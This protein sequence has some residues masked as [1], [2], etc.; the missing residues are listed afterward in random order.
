MNGPP[1]GRIPRFHDP[2]GPGSGAA[3]PVGAGGFS[4]LEHTDQQPVRHIERQHREPD[5]EGPLR[6]RVGNQHPDQDTDRGQQADDR[7]VFPANV[8]IPCWRQAP[9]IETSAII[10]SE[11]EMALIWPMPS[12]MVIVGTKTTPPPTPISPPMMPPIT[13]RIGPP[14]CP[15][16]EHHF[17]RDT[18]QQDGEDEGHGFLRD[19]LLDRGADDDSDDRR[20][21]QDQGGFDVDVAVD[22]ALI[23]AASNAITIIAARL[24]PVAIRSP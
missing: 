20:P 18:D 4:F 23:R 16:A 15:S 24:V 12:T 13:Q 19:A 5:P 9:T 14:E 21:G 3:V 11:V 17:D 22:P 7:G 2:A 6:H 1:L 8:A 10:I